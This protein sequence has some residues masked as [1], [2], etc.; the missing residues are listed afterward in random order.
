MTRFEDFTYDDAAA[1]IERRKA[2]RLGDAYATNH[3]MAE[4]HDFWQGGKLWVGPR[5]SPEAWEARVKA[6]V[7]AQFVPGGAI[8]EALANFTRGLFGKQ[9]NIQAV[10]A[11]PVEEGSAADK[12]LDKEAEELVEAL[13]V[14][15]DRVELWAKM[16]EVGSRSRWAGWGALRLRIPAGRLRERKTADG[17]VRELP[18]FKA[19]AE[20]LAAIELDAPEPDH[21]ILIQHPDTQQRAAI[22]H[23]S[24]K[25]D[26]GQTENHVEL[27][28]DEGEGDQRRTVLRILPEK[29]EAEGPYPY[30]WGG[31]LPV[32]EMDGELMLTEPVRRAEAAL[33]F[34]ATNV[35]R[36]GETAGFRERYTMNAEPAGLWLPT[37]PITEGAVRSM[38]DGKGGTLYFHPLPRS[39]GA[40]VTTDL[41]GIPIEAGADG[42]KRATPGI[43]IADPVDPEYATKVVEFGRAR[44]LHLCHQG[45]LAM[46]ARGES[47]G[48][49]Y[50]QAR[51]TFAGDLQLHV[52]PAERA[53]TQVLEAVVTMAESMMGRPAKVLDRLRLIATLTPD[54]GPVSPEYSRETRELVKEALLSRS[55]AMARLGTDDVAAELDAIDQDPASQLAM[56]ERRAKAMAAFP[57]EVPLVIRAILVGYTEEEARR[58]FGEADAARVRGEEQA[59]DEIRAALER[60]RTEPEGEVAA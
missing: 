35:V 22:F 52:D 42:E 36:V 7:E 40:G 60:G 38:D 39:L 21:C 44:V 30:E 5:G 59:R 47:S 46:T 34:A 56:T 43:E 53:L 17:V 31:R 37:R 32:S 41:V 49:A 1:E 16:R 27:W 33:A 50:E 3:G 4:R 6:A 12:A 11:G 58:Y 8:L 55:T 25:N 28:Y 2:E 24:K 15:W 26:A 57:D 54:A 48:T 18:T 23:Y 20:A 14:W 13:S 19:L 9:A 29:G 45:H 10:P 51:A